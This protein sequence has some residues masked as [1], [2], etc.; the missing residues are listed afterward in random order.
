[1]ASRNRALPLDSH[2][3]SHAEVLKNKLCEFPRSPRSESDRRWLDS[4]PKQPDASGRN[5]GV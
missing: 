4:D 5:R 3:Q 1:M 2:V